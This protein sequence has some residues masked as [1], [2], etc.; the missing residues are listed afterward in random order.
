VRRIPASWIGLIACL[1][2]AGTHVAGGRQ[3]VGSFQAGEMFR[4][5]TPFERIT[6][7]SEQRQRWKTATQATFGS[8]DASRAGFRSATVIVDR[9]PLQCDTTMG[10]RRAVAHFIVGLERASG[11]EFWKLSERLAQADNRCDLSIADHWSIVA[12]DGEAA[13]VSMVEEHVPVFSIAYENSWPEMTTRIDNAQRLIVDA[14]GPSPVLVAR[15][16]SIHFDGRCTFAEE[17]PETRC[18]WDA[19]RRDFV[20]EELYSH[21]KRHSLLVSGTRLPRSPETPSLI[22]ALSQV[23]G[24]VG[25]WAEPDDVGAVRLIAD[26]PAFV[27][28]R[29]TRVFGARPELGA[30][31]IVEVRDGSKSVIVPVRMQSAEP[32]V[33]SSYY[34]AVS[35]Q[36]IPLEEYRLTGPP[37]LFRA[38]PLL[39]DGNVQLLRVVMEIPEFNMRTLYHLA[40]ETQDNTA[41]AYAVKVAS[42][43][44]EAPGPD[45]DFDL[46]EAT[47]ACDP[48]M[49]GFAV[50]VRLRPAPLRIDYDVEPPFL[51]GS[52]EKRRPDQCVVGSHAVWQSGKGFTIEFD[53]ARCSETQFRTAHV[54]AD[55]AM[56]TQVVRS[57][58]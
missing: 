49:P 43:T 35:S 16:A 36:R 24:N 28:G 4:V 25:L 51:T 2:V 18:R 9:E 26:L 58:Q 56:T 5:L 30:P 39:R 48:S 23:H 10:V 55:G 38:Q 37:P 1:I 57:P 3:V 7:T 14:R 19:A 11:T 50:P 20:C 15:F 44:S 13:A 22:P 41:V 31:F 34:T 45:S 8:F 12:G 27:P 29:R 52:Q 54:D 53:R 46:D 40:I 6:P 33:A 47:D 21:A 42:S 32:S 17:R